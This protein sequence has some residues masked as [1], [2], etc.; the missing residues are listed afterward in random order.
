V[1]HG[2]QHGRVVVEQRLGGRGVLLEAA[3]SGSLAYRVREIWTNTIPWEVLQV[4]GELVTAIP[5]G[6]Q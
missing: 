6:S 3:I 1:R 2:V 5:T 4:A